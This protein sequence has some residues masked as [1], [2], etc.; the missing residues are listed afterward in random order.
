VSEFPATLGDQQSAFAALR[1]L[2]RRRSRGE[3]CEL[4]SEEVPAE[5]SHLLAM[6]SRQIVCACRACA[7]L[8][9]EKGAARYRLIPREVRLLNNF[10]LSDLQWEALM[11][12]INLAFFY[13]DSPSE[14]VIALY[15]S[16]AGATESLLNLES[17][18]EIADRNP[19]VATMEPD[20][21]ALLVNRMGTAHDY[22]QV[23]IDECYRLV[24]LIRANWKG[25][26][27][28]PQVWREIRGFF[29]Q[30]RGKTGGKVGNQSA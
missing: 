6:G 1:K 12:P 20:V 4:C 26:S 5:H 22:Y 30:L 13:R 23:P 9:S 29:E 10:Q 8:F 18:N 7:L 21:E 25:L 3:V 19:T 24:G 2:S 15:P 27:G 11:L 17:W 16:P 14:R 28:G